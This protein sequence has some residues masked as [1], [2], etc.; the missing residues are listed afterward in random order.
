MT[1]H[2]N[3][4]D[5]LSKTCTI[6]QQDD[7][8]FRSSSDDVKVEDI[9]GSF[10]LFQLL[11]LVFSGLR[12]SLVAYDSI[13]MS[14]V[15]RPETNY[16]CEDNLSWV[17]NFDYSEFK[18]NQADQCYR[19]STNSS[20][21]PLQRC[22][23]WF[24]YPDPDIEGDNLGLKNSMVVKWSLVCHNEW[25]VAFIETA[26]FAGMLVGNPTWGYYADRVGRR[27]TYLI[28][29]MM[30]LVFGFSSMIAPSVG[31]FIM[32]RFLTAFGIVG[33]YIIYSI[34]VELIGTRHRAF[35]TI[36]NHIGWG[37]GVLV[38]PLADYLFDDYRL[39]ISI[40]PMLTLIM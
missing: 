6:E 23:K 34:Q 5:R 15:L 37:L 16:I 3:S 35:C 39:I 36:L 12:E 1:K 40:A 20:N 7:P 33:T 38:V 4:A 25:L 18:L 9:I 22:D 10:G 30:V 17:R 21:S 31:W 2:N 24:F 27:T 8:E 29:H 19:L 32:F 26:Y 28:T 11:I 14:V 13:V